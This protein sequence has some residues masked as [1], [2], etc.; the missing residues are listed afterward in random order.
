MRRSLVEHLPS[1]RVVPVR[2]IGA[3]TFTISLSARLLDENRRPKA[4]H[5]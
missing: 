5:D 4:V 1:S 2:E 3:F